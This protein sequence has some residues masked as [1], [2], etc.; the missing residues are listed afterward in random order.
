MNQRT[1]R[2]QDGINLIELMIVVAIISII[3]AVAYPAYTRYVEN[4]RRADCTGGLAGLANA[5]ERHYSINGSYL[6]AA[7]A[8]ANTGAPAVFDTACPIDGGTATYNL[9]ISAAT[10]STFTIQAAP[11]G[12]HAGDR[13]GTL[14]LTN[15]GVKGVTGAA[16]GNDWQACWR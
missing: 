11:T 7:A 13:C 16:A 9:T 4:A 15:T 12:A 14:T 3:A 6:G 5:M 10:A 1:I 8:G 2:R